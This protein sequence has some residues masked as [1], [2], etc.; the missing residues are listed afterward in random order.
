MTTLV[1]AQVLH[2]PRD[3]FAHG[4]A[5]LEAFADGRVVAPPAGRLV[6][7]TPPEESTP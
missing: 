6:T 3:P 1:R 5:A 4:P 2:T 7:P